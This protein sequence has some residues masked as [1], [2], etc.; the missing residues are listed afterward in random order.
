MI[1]KKDFHA[2]NL[3]VV[4]CCYQMDYYDVLLDIL[5]VHLGHNS[6]PMLGVNLK[7][8]NYY[9]IYNVKAAEAELKVL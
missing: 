2:I 7:A 3:Y 4:L 8:F 1:E 9:Q 6:D 5:A